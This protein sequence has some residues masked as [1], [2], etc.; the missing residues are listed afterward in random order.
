MFDAIDRGEIK[1]HLDHR[2]QPR[3]LACRT[4]RR[5]ARRW[6]RRELVIVQDAYYPTETTQYAHVLLPAAVNLEQAGTFC[7]S[8]RRVTLMEQVVPPPGDARPDWWWV[9][10]VGRRDG[11]HRG[12]AA[13]TS[14]RQIFDEFARITAGRPNDQSG[15][16]TTSCSANAARSS[17]RTRRW[18]SR[19]APPL[20]R[21]PFPTP[22]GRARFWPAPHTPAGRAPGRRL[23]AAC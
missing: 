17:G 2:H 10:Q 23:P 7:N 21:R 6:R 12:H 20:R 8:E 3:R 19:Q 14:R 15:A 1:A 11:L 18:A 22:T 9:Q 5:S 16:S 4:C 13:S